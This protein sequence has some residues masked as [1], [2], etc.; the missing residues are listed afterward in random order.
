M[1]FCY[2]KPPDENG[3]MLP[4]YVEENIVVEGEIYQKQVSYGKCNK[5]FVERNR[6]NCIKK[7]EICRGCYI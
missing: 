1:V 2:L 7:R 4:H 5:Y 6:D 3:Y